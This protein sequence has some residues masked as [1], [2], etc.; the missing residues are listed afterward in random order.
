MARPKLDG[1][2]KK[3]LIEAAMATISAYGIEDATVSRISANAGLSAGIVHHYFGGKS[4]LL[5]ATMQT[6]LLNLQSSIVPGLR[7]ATHPYE[8]IVA[9]VE[10]NFSPE[11][12]SRDVVRT[13]LAFWNL[14]PHSAEIARLQRIS[15]V[16]TQRNL[17][18]ALK[19][20]V[21]ES[22]AV[23]ISRTLTA[24]MN[25]LWLD[26]ALDSNVCPPEEGRRLALAFVE[27]QLQGLDG[28]PPKEDGA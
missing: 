15:T 5:E 22:R 27:G 25:G 10:G 6:L 12:F 7:K 28:R 19:L 13:W 18:Y 9:I 21:P 11:Q 8:R 20:I 23:T 26:C 17:L 14:A 24:L 16:R 3:Q 2:R 1:V 4:E